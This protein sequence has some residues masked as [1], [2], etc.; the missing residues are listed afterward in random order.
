VIAGYDM[1]RLMPVL[2]VI[3]MVVFGGSAQFG[4]IYDIPIRLTALFI[5]VAI[6]LKD[7]RPIKKL[8]RSGTALMLAILTVPFLQLLPL[9]PGFWVRLPGRHVYGD[10]YSAIGVE[11]PWLPV[12]LAYEHTLDAAL[13]LI[14][15]L[16]GLCAG[17]VSDERT[18]LT[19]AA[20]IIG[21]GLCGAMLG[22]L[23][24]A[25]GV[26]A[27]SYFYTFTN[28]GSTVGFF[29]NRNH[30]GIFLAACIPLVWAGLISARMAELTRGGEVIAALLIAALLVAVFATQSRSAII[31]ALAGLLGSA[32]CIKVR[33][34]KR[35][36]IVGLLIIVLAVGLACYLFFGQTLDRFDLLRESFNRAEV[37][38]ILKGMIREHWLTGI[39]LGN[40]QLLAPRYEAVDTLSLQYWNHAHNDFAQVLAELGITGALLIIWFIWWF[41]SASRRLTRVHRSGRTLQHPFRLAALIIILMLLAHSVVDYP[42]RTGALSALFGLCCGWV[43]SAGRVDV[44]RQQSYWTGKIR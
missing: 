27:T 16:A 5:I 43:A 2:G 26:N 28:A 19:L 15:P 9:P 18:R 41:L 38:P 4:Q 25:Q 21:I 11:R 3:M 34:H 36:D 22:A 20:S 39:G 44:R 30:H 29:A 24:L 31:I 37:Y 10:I 13:F 33:E 32:L 1:K 40:F 14:V 23:Q 12:S 42:L 35:H 7:T 6:V 17:I 8:G